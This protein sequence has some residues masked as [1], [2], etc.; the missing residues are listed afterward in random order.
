MDIENCDLC[1]PVTGRVILRLTR[2]EAESMVR[3]GM[4]KKKLGKRGRRKYNFIPPVM[5]SDSGDDSP[6][7]RVH[8][9]RIAAGLTRC[10]TEAEHERMIGWGFGHVRKP[11]VVGVFGGK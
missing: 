1:D 9:M 5:P 2:S 11:A 7:L 6:M 8:D 4:A 10:E 3:D